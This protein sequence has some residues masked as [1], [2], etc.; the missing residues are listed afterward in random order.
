MKKILV[1]G[2]LVSLVTLIQCTKEAV[3]TVTCSGTTP[4]YTADIKPILDASCASSGCHSAS[5]KAQGYDLS[6]YA[7]AVN[8][9]SKAAFLGS[10]Q[11]KSG[12]SAMPKGAS[13]LSDAALTKIACWVQNGTPQ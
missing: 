11:H 12:Y 10:I 3:D 1:I 7:G 9:A 2:I 6:S 13:K 4:T 8:G 5:S